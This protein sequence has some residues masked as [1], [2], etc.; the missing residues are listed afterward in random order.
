MIDI[1][2]NNQTSKVLLSNDKVELNDNVFDG[3]IRR[4][5]SH[6]YEVVKGNTTTHVYLEDFDKVERKIVLQINGKSHT[7]SITT[8]VDK[9]MQ[10]LGMADAMKVK[11][12]N[13]RAPM[14]GLVRNVMAE[15]G[16]EVRKG[17]GLLVLEAMKM[18]NV[19]KSPTDGVIKSVKT[20]TGNN[21]EKGAVLI[22][23]E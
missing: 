16:Q 23:F 5:D 20:E 8:E 3:T 14:P 1:T 13:L 15:T 22:E 18:E 12:S 4:I 17:D 6:T 11:V 19:I 2:H 9:M 21:V 10:K 7:F